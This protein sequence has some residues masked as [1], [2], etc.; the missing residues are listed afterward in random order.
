MAYYGTFQTLQGNQQV[1]I[2]NQVAKGFEQLASKETVMR[3]GGIYGLE[4]V[5]NTSEQYHQPVLEALCAF[6]RDS[7]RTE[8]GDGPPATDIQA[9]LTVLE[10][11]AAVG[12]GV[13]DLTGARIQK[14]D[15]SNTDL[16]K[17]LL[18]DVLLNDAN[19]DN[20]KLSGAMLLKVNMSGASLENTNLSHGF[21]QN[22]NLG[23][24]DLN[25]ANLARANLIG[26]NLSGVNVEFTIIVNLRGAN[27]AG[28]ILSG[29]HLWYG[30]L[31]GAIL[32]HV[33]LENAELLSRRYT[34][35][36]S[37]RTPNWTAPT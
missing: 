16:T 10:R 15:L 17:A 1:A 12:K 3:L 18:S 33:N 27:L 14:A 24:A 21:L 9:A 2:S 35:R 25:G 29:A 19:L 11:R 22:A 8:T 20:A 23:G 13:V 7:T 4:G 6:V 34:I 31:S 5:M 37:S 30:N 36:R 32:N 26:A 28:A